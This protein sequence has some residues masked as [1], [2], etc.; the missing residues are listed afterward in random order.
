MEITTV[1]QVEETL[2]KIRDLR[3]ILANAEDRRDQSI[4]YLRERIDEAKRICDEE[5]LHTREEISALEYPLEKYFR[6]NPPTG[7][8]KS[9][10]FS[11]GSFGYNKA[12]TKFFLDGQEL[13]A[14]NPDLLALAKNEH[15]EF[16]KV[17]ESV[18]WA[19][20]KNALDFND[21]TVFFKD[22]GEIFGGVQV[23]KRFS[24]NIT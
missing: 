21:D 18:D 13:N 8:R 15:P 10:K 9:L 1:A 12:Q 19:K 17:K 11:C 20:F 14:D 3:Q 6:K 5:T 23:Q 16:V 2:L 22:T 7:K 4:A 24:V